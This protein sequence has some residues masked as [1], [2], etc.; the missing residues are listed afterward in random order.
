MGALSFTIA[1]AERLERQVA[2]EG[3][4]PARVLDHPSLSDA[5]KL[6]L[7]VRPEVLGPDGLLSFVDATVGP[8]ACCGTCTGKDTPDRRRTRKGALHTLSC[9][10]EQQE[11]MPRGG[12]MT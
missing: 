8:A 1:D 4:T 11:A 5:E 10:L 7:L 6:W 9:Y 3:L 12:P 2:D